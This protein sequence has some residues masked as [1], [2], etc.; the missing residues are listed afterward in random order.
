[1]TKK[2]YEK[3]YRDL[4]D[5]L[6]PQEVADLL[7]VNIKTVYKMLRDKVIPSVRVGREYRV[8]KTKVI[9]YLRG[10]GKKNTNPVYVLSD[11]S[12]KKVWTMQTVCSIVPVA[13][14]K[15]ITEGEKSHVTKNKPCRKCTG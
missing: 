10:N 6:S 5:A 7:R 8:A 11:N 14:S 3:K 12:R 4:P 1:M 2:E 15:K 9:E 13:Q